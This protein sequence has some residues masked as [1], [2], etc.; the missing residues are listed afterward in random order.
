MQESWW[1][2]GK[3]IIIPIQHRVSIVGSFRGYMVGVIVVVIAE[4]GG[5]TGQSTSWKIQVTYDH[6]NKYKNVT[7]FNQQV[8]LQSRKYFITC[9]FKKIGLKEKIKSV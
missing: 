8:T 1:L 7:D 3:L 4:I 2:V 5:E 9:K 6:N